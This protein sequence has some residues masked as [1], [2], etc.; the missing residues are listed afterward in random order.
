MR[1]S[2]DAPPASARPSASEPPSSES[3][4]VRTIDSPRLTDVVTSNVSGIPRPSSVSL[5][6]SIVRTLVESEL[7]GSLALGRAEAGGASVE[8]RIPLV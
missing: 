3:T 2:T 5:G 4:R 1:T 7:G 6:L 8:V